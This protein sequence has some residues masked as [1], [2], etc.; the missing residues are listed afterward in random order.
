MVLPLSSVLITQTDSTKL[1]ST[2]LMFT[3]TRQEGEK[4]LTDL[5]LM[6]IWLNGEV[7][8]AVLKYSCFLKSASL[9]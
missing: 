5:L 4:I 6:L 8:S 9:P 2:Y 7:K 3:L 1:G